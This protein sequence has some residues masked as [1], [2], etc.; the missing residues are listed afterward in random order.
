MDDEE[1][2]KYYVRKIVWGQ[3]EK[4]PMIPGIALKA[5]CKEYKIAAKSWGYYMDVIGVQTG[6]QIILWRDT[7]SDVSF[8]GMVNKTT[9]DIDLASKKE[10]VKEVVIGTFRKLVTEIERRDYKNING[11]KAK[12]T[13]EVYDDMLNCLPPLAWKD[14]T[15]YMSEFQT[16]SLTM[17]FSKEGEQ[18]Y[19]SIVDFREENPE[20]TEEEY[21]E[22]RY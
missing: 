22:A 17:K 8:L 1:T 4:M 9:G 21:L 10:P 14:D 16:G 15:F 2:F 7:G 18:H 11:L 13:E 3:E 19:C 6:K 5:V 12:V 20:M